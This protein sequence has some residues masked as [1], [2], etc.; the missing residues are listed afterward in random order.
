MSTDGNLILTESVKYFL[1]SEVI[2]TFFVKIITMTSGVVISLERGADFIRPSWCHCYSL[3]LVSV[4]SRL[5]LA[6]WYWLT[7]V[8]FPVAAARAWNDLPPMIRA[9]PLLLTFLQQLRTFFFTQQHFSDLMMGLSE[10]NWV[11]CPWNV[12]K[13]LASLKSV[14]T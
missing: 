4:K 7:R 1:C 11:K 9:S 14:P 8:A 12:V 5:V 13:C 3:C 10:L 6:F 2:M